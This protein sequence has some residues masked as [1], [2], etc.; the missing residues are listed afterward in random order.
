[1]LQ[2]I[3]GSLCSV[4]PEERLCTIRVPPADGAE[5]QHNSGPDMCLQLSVHM[6]AGYPSSSSPMAEVDAMWLTP[7]ARER[8]L[9]GLCQLAAERAGQVVVF[10]WVEW[11]KSQDWLWEAAAKWL[12]LQQEAFTAA[13]A[14]PGKPEGGTHGGG[15]SPPRAR[16]ELALPEAGRHGSGSGG[17]GGNGGGGGGGSGSGAA[18]EEEAAAL[19]IVH[20]EAFTVKQ[21]TFQAHVARVGSVEE[22]RAVMGALLR[23]R[24][25]ASATHNI[26]AYRVAGP[27]EG[28]LLQDCDD[29]GEAA[30]GG[31]LLHLLQVTGAVDVVAV[32]S[33]WFGGVLLGP[34][35]FKHINNAARAL[36]DSC[37]LIAAAPSP[38]KGGKRR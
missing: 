11:L 24:R 9:E 30:A 27:R 25:V 13:A 14:R 8:A 38:A 35:R 32:V 29:D 2:A 6:P 12:A 15:G 34:M 31:R 17:T 28:M 3:Y 7:A 23:N 5:E 1:M 37:G 36:L 21:S 4:R 19:G 33:R 22:V 26:M 10:A 18:E 16:Q 20:G